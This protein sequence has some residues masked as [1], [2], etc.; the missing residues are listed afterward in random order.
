MNFAVM[1]GHLSEKV[2]FLILAISKQGPELV[3]T[4]ALH[5]A[6]AP[7]PDGQGAGDGGKEG[8]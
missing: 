8:L 3:H 4:L 7:A 2:A 1:I 5:P 6:L